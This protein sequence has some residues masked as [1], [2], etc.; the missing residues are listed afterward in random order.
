VVESEHREGE[1]CWDAGWE[2]HK[3][4]QLLRLARLPLHQKLN[5]LEGAQRVVRE[6]QRSAPSTASDD[7]PEQ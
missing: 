1:R 3:L 7:P 5:W 6:L 4:A 2:G